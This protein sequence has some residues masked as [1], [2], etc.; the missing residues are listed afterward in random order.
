MVF[1]S[2]SILYSDLLTLLSS[3][4]GSI[5]FIRVLF[6]FASLVFSSSS[7]STGLSVVGSLSLFKLK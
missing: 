2:K 6:I 3:I 1:S 7:A 4:L 5:N